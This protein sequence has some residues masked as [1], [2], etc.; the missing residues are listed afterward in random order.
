MKSWKIH[1]LM[2]YKCIVIIEIKAI[3]IHFI[4]HFCNLRSKI[5]HFQM[6][7]QIHTHHACGI[8]VIDSGK[9]WARVVIIVYWIF[10]GFVYD[11]NAHL[12]D[13]FRCPFTYVMYCTYMHCCCKTCDDYNKVCNA[14][15]WLHVTQQ[16]NL[17]VLFCHFLL[18]NGDIWKV[19]ALIIYS[20]F[21]GSDILKNTI[22]IGIK[23]VHLSTKNDIYTQ[24]NSENAELWVKIN[25]NYAEMVEA[26]K[27]FEPPSNKKSA[28]NET[29]SSHFCCQHFLFHV[30]WY[31]L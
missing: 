7:L 14:N 5:A 6:A 16:F 15:G 21:R 2:R 29:T 9:C 23:S 27:T 17:C 4:S 30:A 1:S 10:N 19:D 31:M 24:F 8:T 25:Q 20:V 18:R 12:L 28:L 22:F 3:K 13:T 26:S 11:R